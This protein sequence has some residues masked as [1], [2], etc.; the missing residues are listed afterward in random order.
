MANL[1]GLSRAEVR[2][3]M[4]AYTNHG[5]TSSAER[6]STKTKWKESPYIEEDCV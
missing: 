5:K 2:K 6:N 3:V 4:M 1:L